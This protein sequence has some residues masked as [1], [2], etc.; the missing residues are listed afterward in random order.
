MQRSGNEGCKEAT[1]WLPHLLQDITTHS[2]L[3]MHIQKQAYGTTKVSLACQ[4]CSL[5]KSATGQV[6]DEH[7]CVATLE[8]Q[9]ASGTISR[10]TLHGWQ[11]GSTLMRADT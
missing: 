11:G 10:A 2:V 6:M 1:S 3:S 4:L 9:P 8:L 5:F 7:G